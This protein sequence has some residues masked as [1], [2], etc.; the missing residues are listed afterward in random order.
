MAF[1]DDEEDTLPDEEDQRKSAADYAAIQER[2]RRKDPGWN[3]F[4]NTTPKY[5]AVYDEGGDKGEPDYP[6]APIIQGPPEPDYGGP[7]QGA[8]YPFQP[9]MSQADVMKAATPV[10]IAETP[11][12]IRTFAGNTETTPQQGIG[13]AYQSLGPEGQKKYRYLMQHR[14]DVLRGTYGPRQAA[15]LTD[16]SRQ[17]ADLIHVHEEGVAKGVAK[18]QATIGGQ[19]A[20]QAQQAAQQ[21]IFSD[22]QKQLIGQLQASEQEFRMMANR[23]DMSEDSIRQ[24][25]EYYQQAYKSIVPVGKTG[26]PFDPRWAPDEQPGMD[27]IS[28]TTNKHM[29]RDMDGTQR[30][31]KNERTLSTLGH[32]DAEKSHKLV[33]ETAALY[34]ET[35]DQAIARLTAREM[36]IRGQPIPPELQARLSK[37]VA[38]KGAAEKKGPGEAP[39]TE[40]KFHATAIKAEQHLGKVWDADQAKATTTHPEGPKRLW[41]NREDYIHDEMAK[42]GLAK[43]GSEPGDRSYKGY[44]DSWNALHG[45]KGQKAATGA[46]EA[47]GTPEQ[48]APERDNVIAQTAKVYEQAKAANDPQAFMMQTLPA[49]T[50]KMGN[51]IMNL[52]PGERGVY[53]QAMRAAR[54]YDKAIP[55][56]WDTP[57]YADKI[58]AQI[59]KANQK[60][61]PGF[62]AK[63]WWEP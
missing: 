61:E 49:L 33:S 21:P 42:M 57:E 26:V 53:V 40:D 45:E 36:A 35:D 46:P 10:A 34:G 14:Q 39:M 8:E 19:Q 17:M 28:K 11:P 31:F 62:A 50:K 30:E 5:S 27:W 51:N 63:H 54:K 43:Q 7:K 20:P 60:P 2:L 12:P 22:R 38:H 44:L 41:P 16:I 3:M 56:F 37:N 23:G 15:A 47:G 58:G 4:N 25:V 59:P 13:A 9:P 32:L 24:G 29:T 48:A 6:S 55:S 18:A 1:D 52:S